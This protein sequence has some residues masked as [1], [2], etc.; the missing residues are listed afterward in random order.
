MIRLGVDGLYA[1]DPRVF[2]E[3]HPGSRPDLTSRR[4]GQ[5]A[6]AMTGAIVLSRAPA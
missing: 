2:L 5:G 6:A 3:A 1:D 4:S